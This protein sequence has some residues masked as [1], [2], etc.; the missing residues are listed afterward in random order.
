M[1]A[2]ISRRKGGCPPKAVTSVLVSDSAPAV[3][4]KVAVVSAKAV[5]TSEVVSGKVVVAS[6][7]HQ[8][9]MWARTRGRFSSDVYW[10]ATCFG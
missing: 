7:P 4:C 5:V 10:D 1:A 6:A 2:S 9:F 8:V 3:S